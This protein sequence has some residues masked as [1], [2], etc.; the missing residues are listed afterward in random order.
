MFKFY[1]KWRDRRLRKKIIFLFLKNN[2]YDPA[3]WD[4]ESADM[5]IKY[6]KHG[7]TKEQ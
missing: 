5:Y 7:R 3:L 6:I 2:K 1:Q 4:F